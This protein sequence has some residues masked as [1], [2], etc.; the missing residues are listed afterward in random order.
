MPTKDKEKHGKLPVVASP[1]YPS[2]KTPLVRPPYV[3]G[4][5]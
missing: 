2:S 5:Q 1:S 4:A 3:A